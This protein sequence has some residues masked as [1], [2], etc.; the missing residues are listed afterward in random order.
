MGVCVLSVDTDVE[1][2]RVDVDYKFMF[3]VCDDMFHNN[4]K[5]SED[6]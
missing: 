6:Q 1:T 5:I 3:F 2:L 4:M